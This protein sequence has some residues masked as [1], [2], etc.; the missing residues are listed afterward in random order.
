MKTVEQPDIN[1]LDLKPRRNLQW[2]TREN[3]L[4]TVII[5]KFKNKYLVKWFV[6]LLAKPNIKLKLDKYGSFVWS[7]CDGHTSV[8]QI[9][10]DMAVAF[11]EPVE[12]LYERIGTFVSKLERDKFL[13]LGI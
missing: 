5:P 12:T 7:R 6:P 4:V 11:G 13:L 3:E 10:Q 2:E 8:Q 9:G 1:L